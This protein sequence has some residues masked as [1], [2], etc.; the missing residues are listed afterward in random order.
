MAKGDDAIQDC[1]RVI[2][3]CATCRR[4]PRGSPDKW[5]VG[6]RYRCSEAGLD[7]F[8]VAA[9]VPPDMKGWLSAHA[10]LV[11]YSRSSLHPRN[12]R[13]IQRKAGRYGALL[14]V[15][16]AVAL[17][18]ARLGSPWPYVG[19]A[20]AALI[21]ADLLAYTTMAAFVTQHP[22]VPMRNAMYG[23]VGLML[24]AL[25]FSVIYAGVCRDGFAPQLTLAD[26]VYFSVVTI[27]TVGY[28]DIQPKDGARL[29]AAMEM[30]TGLYYLVVLVATMVGWVNAPVSLPSEG[31]LGLG[32]GG[33][34]GRAQAGP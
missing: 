22:Q 24:L 15:L 30:L 6:T 28:G 7:D 11:R 32:E 3:W 34:H 17:C 5:R 4:E 26:A 14:F 12:S 25:G 8:H 2:A 10:A 21:V 18:L 33:K 1:E 13:G 16:M 20:I 31:D 27:T 9:I 19:A 29:V 23:L